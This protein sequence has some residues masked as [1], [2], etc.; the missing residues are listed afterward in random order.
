MPAL[1][2]DRVYVVDVKTNPRKPKLDKVI[3]VLIS[4]NTYAYVDANA[5]AFVESFDNRSTG[6]RALGASCTGSWDS[7]HNAL[8]G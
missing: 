6:Y 1:G 4:I 8:S 5:D 3:L 7:S 2:S